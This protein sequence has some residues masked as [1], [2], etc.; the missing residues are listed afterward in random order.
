MKY[1]KFNKNKNYN[2]NIIFVFE[3]SLSSVNKMIG[4]S[5]VADDIKYSIQ[6]NVVNGKV[7][8]NNMFSSKLYDDNYFLVGA[9]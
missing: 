6:N 3:D 1:T 5:L 8:S 9:W 2:L 7:N 4:K